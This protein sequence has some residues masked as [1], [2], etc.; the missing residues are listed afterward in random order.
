MITELRCNAY[1]QKIG[2]DGDILHYEFFIED[3]KHKRGKVLF[4]I[5]KC[6]G[7]ITGENKQPSAV[8]Y[9]SKLISSLQ[10]RVKKN[11]DLDSGYVMWY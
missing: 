4:D 9:A 2:Q 5:K 6:D 8:M 3:S 10:E 1:F 11:I 7:E